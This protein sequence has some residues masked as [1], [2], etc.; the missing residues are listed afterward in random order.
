MPEVRD[1]DTA[2]KRLKVPDLR[3]GDLVLRVHRDGAYPYVVLSQFLRFSPEKPNYFV[4]EWARLLE[5]TDLPRSPPSVKTSGTWNGEEGGF[6]VHFFRK[7]EFYRG[8]DA[9]LDAL[10]KI[11]GF[12]P[13]AASLM[14][15]FYEQ[16]IPVPHPTPQPPT[17]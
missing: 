2:Q 8:P 16:G 4:A 1:A 6:L 11:P 9:I 17:K 5:P 3:K 7:N 15:Q 10:E 12:A 14:A 13:H